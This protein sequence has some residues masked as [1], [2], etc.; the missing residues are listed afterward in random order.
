MTDH[1]H[2]QQDV[3]AVEYS[4]N[5][6]KLLRVER[7]NTSAL[8]A[9]LESAERERDELSD[10]VKA[11]SEHLQYHIDRQC[12]AEAELARRD[13]AAGEPDGYIF[14]HPSGKNF[15]SV[16]HDDTAGHNGVKPF[17]FAA[18]PAMV[19]PAIST[20]GLDPESKD[21]DEVRNLAHIVG[22]NWMREQAVALGAQQQKVVELPEEA[23]AQDFGDLDIVVDLGEVLA[24]LDAANVK[25]EVKK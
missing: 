8:R 2:Y 12:K 4:Q 18:Q 1:K 20:E 17:Y 9:E 3:N 7:E 14:C 25:Y 22:A 11:Y 10:D 19:P 16:S 13:A 5:L 21:I 23:Y 15:W 24:V 6:E